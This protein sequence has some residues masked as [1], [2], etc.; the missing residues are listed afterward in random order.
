M[1]QKELKIEKILF[2][3]LFFLHLQQNSE[4][5][6]QTI[7]AHRRKDD[8]IDT[9]RGKY[10]TIFKYSWIGLLQHLSHID[11]TGSGP[12]KNW[13]FIE[14]LSWESIEEFCSYTFTVITLFKAQ[15]V[16]TL[17]K[18]GSYFFKSRV[19]HPGRWDHNTFV[20][21]YLR[22]NQHSLTCTSFV[23]SVLKCPRNIP[24]SVRKC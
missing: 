13:N 18:R 16:F 8:I 14:M 4:S 17:F 21:L 10:Q 24:E 20:S 1:D 5:R 19:P 7:N 23:S 11:W 9:R 12:V 22:F 6:T 3:V 2:N 15:Y